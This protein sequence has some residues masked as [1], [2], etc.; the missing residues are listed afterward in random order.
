M[1]LEFLSIV[2]VDMIFS[3]VKIERRDSPKVKG[4]TLMDAPSLLL[5]HLQPVRSLHLD[6]E[7]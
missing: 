2:K 3:Y 6:A 5:S 1:G 7:L 4:G